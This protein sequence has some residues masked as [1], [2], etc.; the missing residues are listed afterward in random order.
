LETITLFSF[1]DL[2]SLDR[3]YI[4]TF[5][6]PR[7]ELDEGNE[8]VISVQDF[9]EAYR[10]WNRDDRPLLQ[11]QDQL[12]RRDIFLSQPAAERINS[13]IQNQQATVSLDIS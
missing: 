11:I 6:M 7:S 5:D 1:D 13:A 10:N 8:Y 12:S 4:E 2:F 9:T 3:G